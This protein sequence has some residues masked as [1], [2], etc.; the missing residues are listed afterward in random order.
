MAELIRHDPDGWHPGEREA[1]EVLERELPDDWLLVAHL[2]IPA[3]RDDRELDLV[4]VGDRLVH[5]VEVKNCPGRITIDAEWMRS[6]G[7][8]ALRSPL[9]QAGSAARVLRGVLDHRID[10]FKALKGRPV[11]SRVVFANPYARLH[12]VDAEVRSRVSTI[13]TVAGDLLTADTG[14]RQLVPLRPQLKRYFV[15]AQIRDVTPT[16]LHGFRVLERLDSRRSCLTFRCEHF[17]DGSPWIVRLLRPKRTLNREA[18]QRELEALLTEYRALAGL[19]PL[20]VAPRVELPLRLDSDQVLV[21][22]AEPEGQS[23]L[24]LIK[25]GNRPDESEVRSVVY[26]A[27][28]SLAVVHEYGHLHRALTPERVVLKPDGAVL[29]TDFSVAHVDGRTGLSST[30]ADLDPDD[31]HERYWRAPETRLSI[32]GAVEGSDVFALAT[33]LKAWV[34]GS[35]RSSDLRKDTFNR[36]LDA[37]QRLGSCHDDFVSM[38][39]ACRAERYVDGA[40]AAEVADSWAPPVESSTSVMVKD[41]LVDP[42]S[43]VPICHRELEP[44]E[45][46][47][48]RF[49]VRRRLGA[50]ATA[51]T[52]LAY[53]LQ[54]E[55]EVVLKGLDFERVPVELAKREFEVLLELNH[56]HIAVVRDR[57]RPEHPYH[58]VI[59]YAPGTPAADRLTDYVGDVETV[60]SIA[61]ALLDGLAY[62]HRRGMVHRDISAANVVL[63]DP[64]PA[65]LKLV[66]F[67]LAGLE[68]QVTGSVGTPLYR[69]PEIEAGGAWTP[70]CDTYSAAVLLY[71][72]LTGDLPYSVRNG[73]TKAIPATIPA[74]LAPE[75]HR[76]A[77]L[78]LRATAFDPDDRFRDGAEFLAALTRLP[79]AEAASGTLVAPPRPEGSQER[80]SLDLPEVATGSQRPDVPEGRSGRGS[81]HDVQR[82][83]NRA[84]DGEAPLNVAAVAHDGIEAASTSVADDLAA[85]VQQLVNTIIAQEARRQGETTSRAV[86]GPIRTLPDPPSHSMRSSSG[87]LRADP[88]KQRGL[89]VVQVPLQRNGKLYAKTVG[90]L[91]RLTG[92][93]GSGRTLRYWEPYMVA[94]GYRIVPERGRSALSGRAEALPATQVRDVSRLEVVE[95]PLDPS[96]K[97][98]AKTVGKLRRL[99]GHSSKARTIA[100]WQPYMRRA[101]YR[102]VVRG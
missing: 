73:L 64:D 93:D 60:G 94:A 16:D 32:L 35:V 97:L 83:G 2:V 53:D 40:T 15:G 50:G 90:K 22:I 34:I 14:S 24:D 13:S 4:V 74:S 59:D 29:L 70:A 89:E 62:L 7:G 76:L 33:T 55:R 19:A 65:D 12:Q 77:Q 72:L 31:D 96:G 98:Y 61:L 25:Q 11:T 21:A 46:I 18:D 67:G 71:Q 47:D 3:G 66:D 75:A 69:A 36:H 54:S 68:A 80:P 95:V 17:A 28:R 43:V 99:T 82:G 41:G 49:V 39:K 85:Q 58:L 42:T 20:G 92:H 38:L 78:L 23:L 87:P 63:G 51:V 27:F 48:E 30:L 1:A 102:L 6:G 79:E 26:E 84:A 5:N 100:Y 52:V 8:T 10:G 9:V 88:S 81:D 56:D 57:Y 86:G 44:G 37:R 45:R 91:R 101:G